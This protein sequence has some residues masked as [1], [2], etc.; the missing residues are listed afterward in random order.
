ML[1]KVYPLRQHCR[2]RFRVCLTIISPITHTIQI[3]RS[4]FIGH[5]SFFEDISILIPFIQIHLAKWYRMSAFLIQ[6]HNFLM[7][8]FHST[9][10]ERHCRQIQQLSSLK[11]RISVRFCYQIVDSCIPYIHLNLFLPILVIGSC[12]KGNLFLAQQCSIVGNRLR[13]YLGKQRR[14]HI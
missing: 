10:S 9:L 3:H 8:S 4:L 5:E 12:R 1:Q 2:I 6:H 7:I 14:S 11:I 13:S